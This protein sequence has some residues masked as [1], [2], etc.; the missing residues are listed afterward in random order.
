M[1]NAKSI[2]SAC[3]AVLIA[4]LVV[5]PCRA[6]TAPGEVH[7]LAAADLQPV[8]P[9]LTQAYEHAT[10]I[11]LVVSFGSSATLATQIVNG[12]PADLFMAA[13]FSFPEKVVAAGL[14]D[15]PMPIPYA[16]GALVLWARKDSPLQPL[17][18]NTLPEGKFKSLAIANPEHAP[19]GRAAVEAL[20]RFKIYTVV[21]P[22]LVLAENIAQAAQFVESGNADLGIISLTAASTERLKQEGSYVMIP[23][24]TYFPLRQCAVVMKNSPHRG[25]AHAFLDWLR[26]SAIQ[27]NL[28]L[29]GL[30]PVDYLH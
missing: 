12:A 21:Q 23:S 11:K 8:M 16:R 20:N 3:Q 17:T 24:S 26:S 25:D 28:H 4:A 2:R 22:R 6:Q 19:Y 30:Q 14:A 29:Y 10:G 9:A 1:W 5:V 7:V 18:Q 27:R 15:T 13:D